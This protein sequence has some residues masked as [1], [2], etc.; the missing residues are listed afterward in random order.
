MVYMDNSLEF[1]KACEDLSWSHD[2]SRSET[3]GIAERAVRRVEA[4]TL[5]AADS[6]DD[7]C[8]GIGLVF[9]ARGLNRTLRSK[10]SEL[11][12]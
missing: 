3:T 11:D 7:P 4:D 2:K 10:L 12:D 5:T 8:S 6:G 9:E 1:T